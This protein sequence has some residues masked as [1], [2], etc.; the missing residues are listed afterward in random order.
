M[1]IEEMFAVIN[2]ADED[3]LKELKLWLFREGIRVSN[4]A[5]ELE[6]KKTI[7]AREFEEAK[8]ENRR[9][10]EHLAARAKELRTSEELI[11]KKFDSIKRGF[12]ELDYDRKKLNEREDAIHRKEAELAGNMRYGY[13]INSEDFA[14]LMFNGADNPLLLKKRYKDLMKMYHPDC[15]GGDT[16]MMKAINKAYDRLLKQYDIFSDTQRRR[17]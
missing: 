7:F 14:D 5:V 15:L 12:A 17:A 16:E 4:E 2:N 8:E 6:G 10:E 9:Y 1:S 11:A 3:E 13:S